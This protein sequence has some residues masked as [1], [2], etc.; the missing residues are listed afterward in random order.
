MDEAMEL[1]EYLLFS[2]AANSGNEYLQFLWTAR[3]APKWN[4]ITSW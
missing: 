3:G 1:S 2:L 4:A